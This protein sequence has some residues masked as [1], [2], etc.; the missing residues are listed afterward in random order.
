MS[1][2]LGVFG[3]YILW[4]LTFP[5]STLI[6]I[7][8]FALIQW[9]GGDGVLCCFFCQ[10]HVITL[11][12]LSCSLDSLI[13]HSSCVFCLHHSQIS[14]PPPCLCTI[15]TL[16]R[17][18]VCGVPAESEDSH[19]KPRSHTTRGQAHVFRISPAAASLWRHQ[20]GVLP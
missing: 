5:F 11:V 20:S 2:V 10:T 18:P 15:D 19:V 14:Q 16:C 7:Y 12:I 4:S 17:S 13:C 6:L 1:L 9:V 3:C 8:C